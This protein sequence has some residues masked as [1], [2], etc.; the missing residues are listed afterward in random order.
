[1]HLGL[2]AN[3]LNKQKK[4]VNTEPSH[5]AKVKQTLS[6]TQAIVMHAVMAKKLYEKRGHLEIS[7]TREWLV[8]LLALLLTK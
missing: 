4:L 1:M 3:R 7:R 2:Y 5:E 8:F 6:S